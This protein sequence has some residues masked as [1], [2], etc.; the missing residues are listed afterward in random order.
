MVKY[1]IDITT[2]LGYH[3]YSFPH[4][5]PNQC[6]RSFLCCETKLGELQTPL[7]NIEQ[8]ERGIKYSY[9]IVSQDMRKNRE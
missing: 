7:D 9:P 4:P 1:W 3:I 5:P 6:C 2:L 8:G